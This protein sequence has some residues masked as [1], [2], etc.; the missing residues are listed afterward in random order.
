MDII[1]ADSK[2]STIMMEMPLSIE[3]IEIQSFESESPAI[4][5]KGVGMVEATLMDTYDLNGTTYV[6]EQ[7]LIDYKLN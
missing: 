7:K 2:K 6:A 5:M 1:R 3:G 4:F